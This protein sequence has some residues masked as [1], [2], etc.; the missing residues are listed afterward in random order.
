L[1]KSDA[2]KR[3]DIVNSESD[4]KLI[5]Q[6][7]SIFEKKNITTVYFDE[8]RANASFE[9]SDGLLLKVSPYG[10]DKPRDQWSVFTKKKVLLVKSNGTIDI[11]DNV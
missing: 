9:F 8:K 1:Q 5:E 4:Q 2:E 11:Q 10:N 7:I 3:E 6:K